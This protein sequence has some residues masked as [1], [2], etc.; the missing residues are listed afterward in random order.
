[1]RP[2]TSKTFDK[3]EFINNAAVTTQVKEKFDDSHEYVFSEGWP[4]FK[5]ELPCKLMEGS[6]TL[7]RSLTFSIPENEWNTI[8]RHVESLD[9]PKRKWMRRIVLTAVRREQ[10]YCKK[11][12]NGK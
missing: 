12:K 3:E 2:K 1:M 4:F 7:N 6:S 11:V 8:N 9:L 10:E 5:E